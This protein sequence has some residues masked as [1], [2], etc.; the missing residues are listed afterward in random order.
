MSKL[1]LLKM[2]NPTEIMNIR[3][4]FVFARY[5]LLLLFK[6]RALNVIQMK[7]TRSNHELAGD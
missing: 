2:K 6:S 4:I 3:F 1:N 7:N 5:V